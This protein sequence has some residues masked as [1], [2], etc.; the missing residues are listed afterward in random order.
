MKYISALTLSL[1]MLGLMVPNVFSEYVPDWVKNTAGWW[2]TD[3]ISETEFLNA[4]E[5]LINEKIIQVNVHQTSEAFV[6]GVPDWV[7]NTAGWWAE[8]KISDNEFLDSMEFL[9]SKSIIQIKVEQSELQLLLQKRE[10]LIDF[11]WKE[12]GFPTHFPNSI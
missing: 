5:F 11:I 4:V 6:P 1:F 3:A 2:A 7:K 8:E 10:N 9:I 12:D